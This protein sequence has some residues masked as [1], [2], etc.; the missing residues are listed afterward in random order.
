M[1]SFQPFPDP[2]NADDQG[3]LAMGG[4]LSVSTLVSAYAQGI[5]PWFNEDQPILWWS[6][7]PRLVLIPN[8][9][10]ISRSLRKS[11]KNKFSVTC[12]QAFEQVI[13]GCALRGTVTNNAPDEIQSTS[14]D[15]DATWITQDMHDAYIEL[16]KL[17]YAHSIE[18]WSNNELVGGLYGVCLGKVYFGESMFS[19]RTDASKVALVHLC[20]HLNNKKFRLIDCQV[21]SDHLFTLGAKEI[22]RNEFSAALVDINIDKP[23]S[24]FA[25]E[26]PCR[27]DDL[28]SLLSRESDIKAT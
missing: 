18:V 23:S 2:S 3:L 19:S 15:S 27:F 6:P 28:R 11:I 5:F 17:G 20:G 1:I 10:R 8:E 16:H 22:S 9:V 7:D 13:T 14:L 21:A 4:D 12:N 24:D 26:F 25:D